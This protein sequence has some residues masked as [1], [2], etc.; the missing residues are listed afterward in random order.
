MKYDTESLGSFKLD[1]VEDVTFTTI[2]DG[3]VKNLPVKT[4]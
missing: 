1:L 2:L 3:A 4:D